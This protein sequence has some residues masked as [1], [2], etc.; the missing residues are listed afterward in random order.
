ML[1][2]VPFISD[3]GLSW[4][5]DCNN[6]IYC[7]QYVEMCLWFSFDCISRSLFLIWKY[8]FPSKYGWCFT[9]LH[10]WFT[11]AWAPRD[12]KCAEKLNPSSTLPFRMFKLRGG[13]PD[14]M[15]YAVRH[16]TAALLISITAM[17]IAARKP[18]H[19]LKI[20]INELYQCWWLHFLG[21]RIWMRNLDGL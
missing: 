15:G 6:E 3:L 18:N 21:E 4:T 17:K 5:M 8:W 10:C 19:F 13:M 1:R 16:C 20:K 11:F 2:Y 7:F 12:I 14:Y 9:P